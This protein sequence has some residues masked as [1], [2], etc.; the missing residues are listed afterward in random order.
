MFG[1]AP[2]ED[3]DKGK[4]DDKEKEVTKWLYSSMFSQ[5]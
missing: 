5:N 1:V 2:P 3:S 4:N